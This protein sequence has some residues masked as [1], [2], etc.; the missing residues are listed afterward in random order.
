MR[1]VFLSACLAIGLFVVSAL[2]V[3][4]EDGCKLY[5]TG[6]VISYSYDL[7]GPEACLSH[8]AQTQGCVAWSYTPHNFNPKTAPGECRLL[9]DAGTREA[10]ARDFCGVVDG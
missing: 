1:P 9:P 2:P 6:S 5:P 10:H 7:V 3:A 4:A 8:C